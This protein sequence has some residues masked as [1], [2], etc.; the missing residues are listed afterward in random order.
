MQLV[1]VYVM[2][3]LTYTQGLRLIWNMVPRI[4]VQSCR[5]NSKEQGKSRWDLKSGGHN[6]Q[7]SLLLHS[8]IGVW[9]PPMLNLSELE[10]FLFFI[11]DF[12]YNQTKKHDNSTHA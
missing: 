8:W 4:C 2:K 9:R 5:I 1:N 6:W 11:L 10:I 12:R 7:N 3:H